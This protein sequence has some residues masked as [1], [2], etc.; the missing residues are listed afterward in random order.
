MPLSGAGIETGNI[1]QAYISSESIM[2]VKQCSCCSPMAHGRGLGNRGGLDYGSLVPTLMPSAPEG[3][4]F[5]RCHTSDYNLVVKA[6]HGKWIVL[7]TL[8]A[9]ERISFLRPNLDVAIW[10]AD[11]FIVKGGDWLP[12]VYSCASKTLFFLSECEVVW[13]LQMCRLLAPLGLGATVLW[14]PFSKGTY[15]PTT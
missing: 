14:F 9:S 10:K 11:V 6:A 15:F 13:L 5:P 8:T 2:R 7:R 3:I 4:I 12:W 1:C